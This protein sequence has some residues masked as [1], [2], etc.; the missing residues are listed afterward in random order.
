MKNRNLLLKGLFAVSVFIGLGSLTVLGEGYTLQ[1]ADYPQIGAQNK[2]LADTVG[3]VAVVIGTGG[4]NKT[5]EFKQELKG[6][7]IPH[8]LMTTAGTPYP[9]SAPALGSEWAVRSK[10]WLNIDPIQPLLPNGLRGFFDVYYYQ[11][12]DPTVN[13]IKGVGIGVGIVTSTLVCTGGYSYTNLSKDFPFPLTLH[14]TWQRKTEFSAEATYYLTPTL[15]IPIPLVQSDQSDME[16]DATG[17][18]TLPMGGYDCLRIKSTR[19]VVINA[20]LGTSTIPLSN[21][22]LIMY[23]WWTKNIGLLLQVSSHSGEKNTDFSDAGYVARLKSTNVQTGIGC[24]PEC[25][26]ND[27]R[28]F[29][30]SLQQNFPNPF[31]PSTSI[32]YALSEPSRVEFKVFSL[33]GQ[34]VAVLEI[35]A[36]SA[37]VHSVTWNG[38]DPSGNRMPSGIYFYRLK[39]VPLRQGQSVI[40]TK[41]M[42]MT[43]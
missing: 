19:V 37:G 5:W 3:H 40:L 7:E 13:E 2:L 15:P 6:R 35:G 17:R 27:L 42:I 39:A 22:T 8:E 33:L 26:T 4:E 28:P 23:E 38:K 43:D 20:K 21:D 25:R 32:Q 30:C 10:Q 1:L 34:E 9:A 29:S 36:K 12:L 16:V 31:N 11:K 14:K 24:T 41:K 18:L